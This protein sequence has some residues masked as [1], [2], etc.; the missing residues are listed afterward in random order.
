[1][2]GL[3]RAKTIQCAIP[4]MIFLP[5]EVSIAVES[6]PEEGLGARNPTDISLYTPN[7][8]PT[9]SPESARDSKVRQFSESSAT[10][11]QVSEE[12]IPQDRKSNTPLVIDLNPGQ[13]PTTN[14]GSSSASTP[15]STPGPSPAP[16]PIH[17][18]KKYHRLTH[19][20]GSPQQPAKATNNPQP[21]KH[22]SGPSGWRWLRSVF[23]RK[24]PHT[25]PPTGP[26]IL[27]EK[28]LGEEEKDLGEE[29]KDLGEEEKDLGEEEKDPGEST[30]E[31]NASFQTV[32]SNPIAK[33]R[34]YSEDS[35]VPQNSSNGST[36]APRE[37]HLIIDPDPGLSARTLGLDEADGDKHLGSPT[38]P[39][40]LGASHKTAFSSH[41]Q[42]AS[43]HQGEVQDA[44]KG[45]AQEAIKGA[46][47]EANKNI[48]TILNNLHKHFGKVILYATCGLAAGMTLFIVKKCLEK[49]I[50]KRVFEPRLA[51]EKPGRG[52]FDRVKPIFGFNTYRGPVY[53]DLIL[54]PQEISK[55]NEYFNMLKNA[56]KLE[57]KL[58]S[59]IL[60]G[61]PGTGKTEAT[62]RIAE[63]LGFNFVSLLA[64]TLD[65]YSEQQSIQHVSE[66]FN[67]A[68]NS[69]GK[70]IIFIDKAERLFKTDDK[71]QQSEKSP[72]LVAHFISQT[73]ALSSKYTLIYEL[74]KPVIPDDTMN[75]HVTYQ[76]G[77]SLPQNK[78]RR[79]ISEYYFQENIVD[80]KNNIKN[81][82][83]D[84][85]QMLSAMETRTKGLS[86]AAIEEIFIRA[87]NL[88]TMKGF[89]LTQ[90]M[91]D[92]AT[93]DVL[94]KAG[95]KNS[96]PVPEE[97]DNYDAADKDAD[98][99]A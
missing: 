6:S 85:E 77:I 58:P 11:Q 17:E 92:K 7:S 13:R 79:K 91:L 23:Y 54:Q 1:M 90:E 47:Q 87:R 86:G 8:D 27:E 69:Y 99:A 65:G 71:S 20:I 40:G 29:E 84:P 52:F 75:M 89:I 50:E 81:T 94:E 32:L 24:P 18:N 42:P 39:G 19:P 10:S 74:N 57:N 25:P 51:T 88:A 16:S 76:I 44:I 59:L 33:P 34:R 55:L 45:A 72:N 14:N 5:T 64:S 49:Y 82:I 3:I 9:T 96:C 70:T 12:T 60:S 2:N 61:P 41:P 68:E 35:T 15:E 78:E 37:S 28:D 63:E 53:R 93:D 30:K 95:H 26:R 83:E 48:D 21:D 98:T 97:L 46:A 38:S 36:L 31:T 73:K 56:K 80:G 43:F 4:L 67:R 62:K 66:L 22:S